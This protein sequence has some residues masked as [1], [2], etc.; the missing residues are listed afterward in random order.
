[1]TAKTVSQT[2]AIPRASRLV[3]ISVLFGLGVALVFVAG[4]AHPQALHNA[5]HDSRHSLSFPCH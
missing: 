2:P 5:A 3:A 4:F 1:M